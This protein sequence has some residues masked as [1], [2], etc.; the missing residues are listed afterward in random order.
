MDAAVQ[1]AIARGKAVAHA[2]RIRHWRQRFNPAES[3]IFL[4]RTRLGSGEQFSRGDPVP[5]ET[6]VKILRKW[7]DAM[8]IGI[9]DYEPPRS[10]PM[11]DPPDRALRIRDAIG[12]LD[13]NDADHWTSSGKPKVDWLEYFA[14]FDLTAAERDAAWSEHLKAGEG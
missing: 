7:W 14:G 5:P 3:F 11:A 2:K 4:A 13:V 1:D 10:A 12:K 9:S 8:R 6:P